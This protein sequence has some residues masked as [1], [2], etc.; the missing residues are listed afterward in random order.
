LS[1]LYNLRNFSV[2]TLIGAGFFVLAVGLNALAI[3]VMQ[4]NAAVAPFVILSGLFVA[5]YYCYLLTRV[6][7]P[8]FWRYTAANLSVTLLTSLTI[9]LMVRYGGLSG[10]LST[11]LALCFFFLVRYLVLRSM[12]IIRKAPQ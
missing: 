3:D 8:S 9:W 6:I 12:N 1:S 5:K 2:F 7:V 4:L 10:G 11:G